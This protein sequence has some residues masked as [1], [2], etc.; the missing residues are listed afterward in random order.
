MT[1]QFATSGAGHD[2]GVLYVVVSEEE[3]F[4]YLSD[5]RL[6]N[7]DRP[8]KKR[9]KHIQPMR[10]EVDEGL[11]A[12]LL[13]GEAVRPEE[14]RYAIKQFESNRTNKNSGGNVCQR[15]M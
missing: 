10:A 5:G 8:K 9:K 14:V 2:K 13:A 15:V 12:K 7:P 11:K 1:G 4:V 3:D 6:K